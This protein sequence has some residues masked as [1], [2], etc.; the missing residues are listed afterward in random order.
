MEKTKNIVKDF[1]LENKIIDS[2]NLIY[3]YFYNDTEWF[4]YKLSDNTMKYVNYE[5]TPNGLGYAFCVT[6]KCTNLTYDIKSVF[7]SKSFSNDSTGEWED[8]SDEL[9]DKLLSDAMRDLQLWRN[10]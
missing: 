1:L 4:A 6:I 5:L 10:H 8:I 9:K 3:N 7:Y 2:K